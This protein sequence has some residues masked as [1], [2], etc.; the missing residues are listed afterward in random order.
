MVAKASVGVQVVIAV[1]AILCFIFF[2][3]LGGVNNAYL[4][5]FINTIQLM[6][7]LPLIN[8]KMPGNAAY[9]MNLLMN[10]ARFDFIPNSWVRK[11]F[12]LKYSPTPSE[13]YDQAGYKSTHAILNMVFLE[14]CI[15]VL[16]VV[17]LYIF[18]A[19]R[20]CAPQNFLRRTARVLKRNLFWTFNIRFLLTIYLIL[21]VTTFQNL[22]YFNADFSGIM[23]CFFIIGL[24]AFAFLITYYFMFA[25]LFFKDQN[26][27]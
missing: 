20:C 23:S 14:I 13:P 18:I 8:V 3:Y 26:N 10:L 6:F 22:K 9:L 11:M 7:H 4:W 19:E 12:G 17:W 16:L 5:S 25:K 2:F 21:A 27:K 15:I 1:F 24:F